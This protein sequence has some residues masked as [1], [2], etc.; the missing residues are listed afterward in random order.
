ML[1]KNMLSKDQ[2]RKDSDSQF[3]PS[4]LFK[5]VVLD[6]GLKPE[7]KP[8][9]P[10]TTKAVGRRPRPGYQE[11]VHFNV[12]ETSVVSYLDEV[13]S[14]DDFNIIRNNIK[15]ITSL[16]NGSPELDN[17]LGINP[18][19]GS[20]FTE[21]FGKLLKL[22]DFVDV[23]Q[24]VFLKP[25]IFEL[26]NKY[27]KEIDLKDCGVDYLLKYIALLSNINK[28]DI[29]YFCKHIMDILKYLEINSNFPRFQEL[30]LAV[31]HIELR[32]VFNPKIANLLKRFFDRIFKK[33][34][35]N[36]NQ[37]VIE[38]PE[39][40]KNVATDPATLIN[41]AD[42]YINGKSSFHDHAIL[43]DISQCLLE[44]SA[45]F[46]SYRKNNVI[47][48]QITKFFMIFLNNKD[49]LNVETILSQP[50]VDL[51]DF[52]SKNGDLKVFLNHYLEGILMSE[53]QQNRY[54]KLNNSNI[55]KFLKHISEILAILELINCSTED[56]NKFKL[57]FKARIA[58]EKK[59]VKESSNK[60]PEELELFLNEY[61][62]KT[63]RKNT[64]GQ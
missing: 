8:I 17:A 4:S 49:T 38:Q 63:I 18:T 64:N 28:K 51:I 2:K 36:I 53:G 26:I 3:Q 48:Y 16:I 60:V 46:S 22:G 33:K 40:N 45:S 55:D 61:F 11:L 32:E 23:S 42:Q 59:I 30:Q 62:H 7:V 10:E 27:S 50:L 13:L 20:K 29:S 34:K 24:L 57:I 14:S 47:T 39:W 19:V 15:K 41:I 44:H 12:F 5:G 37:P 6:E 52:K 35:E 43:K 9:I 21:V 58:F 56:Y 54:K 25:P 1:N 31:E